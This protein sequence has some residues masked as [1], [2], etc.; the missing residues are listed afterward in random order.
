M[1]I[2]KSNTIYIFKD[3]NKMDCPENILAHV[4]LN[5]VSDINKWFEES[6]KC[7]EEKYFI[8]FLFDNGSFIRA[9]SAKKGHVKEVSKTFV[10]K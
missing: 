8:Q 10:E 3:N 5:N 4:C 7:I 6:L 2:Q 1:D 9:H